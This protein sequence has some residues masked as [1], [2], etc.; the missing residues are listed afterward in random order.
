MHSVLVSDTIAPQGIAILQRTA[1]VDVNDTITSDE[2]RAVI[3]DYD[4]LIVRSRTKVTAS[5]IASGT[6]LQ[7]IGRAGVG[8]DNIDVESAKERNIRIVS[9]VTSAMIAVAEHTIGLMIALARFIPH[10]DASL[11][12]GE[13]AKNKFL[14]VELYGK[15][16]GLV[17]I[18]R[19]GA[20]VALR[21]LA[22]G[23]RVLAYDPYV[24]RERAQ[25]FGANLLD[26]LDDLLAQSDFVSIHTPLLPSTRGMID[27]QA[28]GKM[29]PN[30]RLI[31][32]ARGGVVD[33]QA[34]LESLNQNKLA[35]AALDVF[36]NEPPGAHPL[37]QHPRVVATPHLG[38][39][40]EEAQ[41][42]AAIDVAQQVTAILNG[43]STA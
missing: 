10:A 19:I 2:L 9:S 26:S 41:T 40:T 17:G 35:G 33:E 29:K 7:V 11:K 30:A 8:L 28:L 37:L 31:F 32:C 27:A 14:G 24:T 16:L 25:E 38:A 5:I 39:M 34:L 13:W 21:A 18:G 42:K 1:R 20:L 3:P 4:A 15:T 43:T 12:H 6:R 36:E 23:M 22:F